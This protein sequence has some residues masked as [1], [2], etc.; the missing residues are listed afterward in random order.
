MDD[1]AGGPGFEVE[2][3]TL[4]EF[5]HLLKEREEGDSTPAGA[6]CLLRRAVF[7]ARIQETW[8]SR[9][10]FP[11]VTR[12]AIAAFAYG[13]AVVCH[14]RLASSAVELPEMTN[15]LEE[16]Q[17]A[18]HEGLRAEVERGLE[19]ADLGVPLYEGSLS[20]AVAR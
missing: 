15:A 7:V 6:Q 4:E 20:R 3:A 19:E 13:W 9:Y 5:L 11:K 12:Y 8:S 16:R 1:S 18:V 2:A 17:W 10:E 14:R